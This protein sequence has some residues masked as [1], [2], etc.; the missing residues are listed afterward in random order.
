MMKRQAAE[1]ASHSAVLQQFNVN[2]APPLRPGREKLD[3]L[4]LV[5]LREHR[6]PVERLALQDLLGLQEHRCVCRLS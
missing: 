5:D 2:E 4:E 3:Q 6:D 1:T